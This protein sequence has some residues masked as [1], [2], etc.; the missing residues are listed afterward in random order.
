M[1]EDHEKHYIRTYIE[2]YSYIETSNG[3]RSHRGRDLDLLDPTAGGPR[4]DFD[5]LNVD[6]IDTQ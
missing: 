1:L 3:V 4:P 5:I 6:Q 2:L